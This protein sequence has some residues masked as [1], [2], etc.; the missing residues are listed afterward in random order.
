MEQGVSVV[1][2]ACWDRSNMPKP[3]SQT[4]STRGSSSCSAAKR[5]CP[6]PMSCDMRTVSSRGVAMPLSQ[7]TMVAT[8]D[9]SS[10]ARATAMLPDHRS[11]MD[12]LGAVPE[13]YSKFTNLASSYF[14]ARPFAS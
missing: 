14:I 3:M 1:L 7:K 9:L 10:R 8:W 4:W 12:P 2:S 5:H 11:Y 13:T 6:R